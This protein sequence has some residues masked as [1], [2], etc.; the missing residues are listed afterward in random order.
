MYTM[1][2]TTSNMII[3]ECM[4]MVLLGLPTKSFLCINYG[5]Y[6]IVHSVFDGMPKF[7]QYFLIACYDGILFLHTVV[8]HISDVT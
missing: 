2:T 7:S 1:T 4:H 6:S 8:W 5:I 3:Y